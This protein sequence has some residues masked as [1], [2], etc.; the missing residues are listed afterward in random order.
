MERVR[1][2]FN[3]SLPS[4]F[5]KIGEY[6]LSTQNT[7]EL[8]ILLML[9]Y[10]RMEIALDLPLQNVCYATFPF[11]AYSENQYR[12]CR[13]AFVCHNAAYYTLHVCIHVGL[14]QTMEIIFI[15]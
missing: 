4:L 8:P 10:H 5:T 12:N 1:S 9:I 11:R 7:L 2:S 13:V 3:H 15:L 6:S 14:C